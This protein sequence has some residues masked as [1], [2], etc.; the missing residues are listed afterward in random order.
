[1]ARVRV[2]LGLCL[3]LRLGLGL[4]LKL[5]LVL[6]LELWIGLKLGLGLEWVKARFRVEASIRFVL[7]G[8]VRTRVRVR[9]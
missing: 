2:T 4:G 9:V 5:C 7:G 6:W 1:L 3:G 8:R